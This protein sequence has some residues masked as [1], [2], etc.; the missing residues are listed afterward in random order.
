MRKTTKDH[1]K[2][3]EFYMLKIW[4]ESNFAVPNNAPYALRLV[5]E[6]ENICLQ[7]VDHEG[8]QIYCGNILFIEEEGDKMVISLASGLSS[9]AGFKLDGDHVAMRP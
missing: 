5:K 4:N 1:M 9:H 3:K 8:K 6:R 7:A 2:R